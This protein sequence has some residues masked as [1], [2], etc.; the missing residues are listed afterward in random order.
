MNWLLALFTMRLRHKV[1]KCSILGLG[2]QDK[3]SVGL[4]PSAAVT[5]SSVLP[6]QLQG[7]IS[8]SRIAWI[9]VMTIV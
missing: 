9:L 3:S 6:I 5:V 2:Y 1:F 4:L 7:L 8:P